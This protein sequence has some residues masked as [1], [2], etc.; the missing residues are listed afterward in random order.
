LAEN[1]R[2]KGTIKFIFW[3]A[4]SIAVILFVVNSYTSG[5]MA[6]W[7]YYEAT[8]DGYA[9]N[10]HTFKDATK[11]RPASLTIVQGDVIDGLQAVPVKKGQRLPANCNGIIG[12]D[13][14]KEGKRAKLDGDRLI[15]S[16]PWQIKES[17]GFKYKD[18]FTHKGVHTN[19]WSGVW[20]VAVVIAVGLC[21]GLMA[22]GFTDML[23]WK[24]KKIEHYGH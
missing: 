18:T 6:R 21:L 3:T 16:V 15:V 23:G 8:T 4:A 20:N 14:L 24:I 1:H 10:A 22:E 11:E 12:N 5:Q 17:K 7:Y 19:P 9:V 13:V 2:K